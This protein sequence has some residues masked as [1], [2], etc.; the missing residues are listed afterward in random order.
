MCLLTEW[1]GP[2]AAPAGLVVV[3]PGE[4]AG[5]L[6]PLPMSMLWG[7]GPKARARFSELGVK[8]IG[9]IAA[10][11]ESDL[12]RWFGSWGVDLH[13]HSRGIDNRPVE[14]E[15]EAKSISQETTFARDVSEG[16]DLRRTLLDLSEQVGASLRRSGL[17]ART[18]RLKLR[19]PPFETLTRQTTLPDATQLDEVIY[20]T[21]VGLFEK[22]WKPGKPVR[23]IGVG[24]S[25]LGEPAKQLG[26][27]DSAADLR[28]RRLAETMDKIRAKY[29]WNAVKRAAFLGEDE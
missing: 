9:D 10:C 2:E 16:A 23:L 17:A 1:Q 7:V 20:S 3:P 5:F 12:V 18:V 14:S 26:L 19:W 8:T 22:E 15:H 4:E 27:F 11:A 28:S 25:G 24:V 29:G 13:W 6:A 21:A